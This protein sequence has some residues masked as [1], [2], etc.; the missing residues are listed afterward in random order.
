LKH[1]IK[2]P[3]I[4][5]AVAVII[6]VAVTLVSGYVSD[7]QTGF[8]G[9]IAGS[10]SAPAQ[11]AMNGAVEWLEKIYGYMYEYD[12]MSEEIERLKIELADAQAQLRETDEYKAE[13]ERLRT[14]LGFAEKRS[15]LV[16]EPAEIIGWT[17]SNWSSAFTIDR[18]ADDGLE[19]GD[20]VIT[21]A[22]YLC[23]QIIETGADWATVRTV[24]DT[25]MYIGVLV[26][27]G[28]N[29]AMSV[30]DFSLMQ[31]GCSKLYYLTEGTQL[32]D[33]DIIV[34]SGRG[35]YFPAGLVVGTVKEVRTEA[36]GQ[37]VYGVIEPSCDLASLTHAY[38]IKEY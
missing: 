16:L 4:I 33:G 25:G 27:E 30:G 7:G 12:A 1:S 34:T 5:L 38:V 29:A 32:F 37:T 10:L 14:L 15:D 8:F 3:A 24:I 2:K 20:C 17:P 28:G 13:A 6:T 23:G 19:V 18:G 21:E 35:E 31:K 26:G 9:G 22:G 11:K 36:G